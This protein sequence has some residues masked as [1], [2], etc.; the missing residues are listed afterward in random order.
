MRP[1]HGMHR[2]MFRSIYG[3]KAHMSFSLSL[4][5][6]FISLS[7]LSYVRL[8]SPQNLNSLDKINKMG[9]ILAQNYIRSGVATE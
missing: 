4:A 9:E 2:G 5:L 8:V 6:C 7:Q 1:V 3:T